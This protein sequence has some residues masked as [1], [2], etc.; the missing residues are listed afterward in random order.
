M[1][2]DDEFGHFIRREEDLSIILQT[3]DRNF[4]VDYLRDMSADEE[5]IAQ[6]VLIISYNDHTIGIF[7]L[8]KEYLVVTDVRFQ[9]KLSNIKYLIKEYFAC[10][11]ELVCKDYQN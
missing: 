5:L 1:K 10:E 8:E 4:R 3:E 9:S 7:D 6:D 11:L 2:F